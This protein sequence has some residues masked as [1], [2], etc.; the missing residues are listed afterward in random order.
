MRVC[1]I[2]TYPP[3]ECGIA[4]YTDYLSTAIENLDKEVVVVTQEGGE[5]KNVSDLFA[6]R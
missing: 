2:S 5:G 1:F 4:T 3:T 6:T